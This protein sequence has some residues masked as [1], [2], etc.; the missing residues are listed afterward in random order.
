MGL[1]Q[2]P[3]AALEQAQWYLDNGDKEKF[4]GAFELAAANLCRQTVEQIFFILCFY[5]GMPK[6]KYINSKMELKTPWALYLELK[7]ASPNSNKKY[8]EIARIR[9][10]R[11]RKFAT[12][13]RT[14]NKWR[15]TLNESAHFS[16]KNRKL[17]SSLLYEYI[18]FGKNLFDCKDR[19]L[20]IA[21]LNDIFSSGRFRA[22]LSG[23]EDNTPGIL[24]RNL[25]SIKD[26]Q[27]TDRG[28]LT[29]S[30]PDQNFHVI[31][32]TEIPRGSW[33]KVPVMIQNA[34]GMAIMMQFEK[35]DG[36]AINIGSTEA[37]LNCFATN[38]KETERLKRH[39]NKLGFVVRS[40]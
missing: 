30:G 21:A 9:G 39:L 25:V 2:D 1:L 35:K 14:L 5:S 36:T 31:S 11:I 40:E 29:L 3:S 10:S 13:P 22:V 23:D 33:P 20:V 4:P 19:Y 17:D 12:K 15:K 18:E 8:I 38:D 6:K 37:L 16:I 34:A 24:I 7:K 28:G 32:S 27:R 26:I